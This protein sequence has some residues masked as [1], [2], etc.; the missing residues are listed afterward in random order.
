MI[1]GAPVYPITLLI[2]RL[3]ADHGPTPSDFVARLGYRNLELGNRRLGSWITTGG[4]SRRIIQQI[5]T[6]HPN[7]ATELTLAIRATEAIKKVKQ[8]N[9][10]VERCKAREATFSPFIHCVGDRTIPHPITIFGVTGGHARWTTIEIPQRVLDLSLDEQLSALPPLMHEY[11]TRFGGHVPFC[12][13]L[14]GFKLVRLVDYFV[15][16]A[17]GILIGQVLEPF[18]PGRVEVHLE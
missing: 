1:H 8:D 13:K 11:V 18:R 2:E 6:A 16:D 15:F 9:E 10:W 3:V 17:K 4:G 14:R 5:A 7:V 12:S